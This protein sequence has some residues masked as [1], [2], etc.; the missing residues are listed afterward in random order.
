[1]WK[2]IGLELRTNHAA[3]A[4]DGWSN[5]QASY[6]LHH[7]DLSSEMIA[8]AEVPCAQ[9]QGLSCQVNYDFRPRKMKAGG[10][11]QALKQEVV[12]PTHVAPETNEEPPSHTHGLRPRPKRSRKAKAVQDD[13]ATATPDPSASTPQPETGLGS[14][15]WRDTESLVTEAITEMASLLDFAFRK[16]IGFKGTCPGMRTVRGTRSPSLIEIA[17]AV[18]DLQY[19]HVRKQFQFP[20]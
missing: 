1:M 14:L 8:P 15:D 7:P 19:L 3:Y 5:A 9:V 20:T 18:W 11:K 10:K 12:E 6:F 17:P 4:Q 16:L 13:R 2:Q